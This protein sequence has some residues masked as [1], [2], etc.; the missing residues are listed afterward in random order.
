MDGPER[1]LHSVD[2]VCEILGGISRSSFYRLVREGALKT[3]KV[4]RLTYVA[5]P[6]LKSYVTGLMMAN[7]PPDEMPGRT[8]PR[9]Y[10]AT[11]DEAIWG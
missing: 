7:I 2:E 6:D 4:G 8:Y 1:L 10:P 5:D 9:T 3:V 11:W